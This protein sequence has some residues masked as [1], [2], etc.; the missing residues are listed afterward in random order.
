MEDGLTYAAAPWRML[1]PHTLQGTRGSLQLACCIDS[2]IM[3]R[4]LQVAV[5]DSTY[6]CELVVDWS[7]ALHDLVCVFAMDA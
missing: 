1:P 7:R 2:D 3:Q 6:E 4:A 5:D